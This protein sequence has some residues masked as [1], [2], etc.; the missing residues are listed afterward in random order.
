MPE[1][2][3]NQ[4]NQKK[5]ATTWGSH[6]LSGFFSRLQNSLAQLGPRKVPIAYKLAII[7]TLMIGSGM[8]LLG[9]MIVS[10]Q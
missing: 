3:D 2:S 7:L 6:L 9:L 1:E 10:N 4:Q 8:G 5:H